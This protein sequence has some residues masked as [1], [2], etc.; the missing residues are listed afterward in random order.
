MPLESSMMGSIITRFDLCSTYQSIF[1][2]IPSFFSPLGLPDRAR[3]NR[4]AN[5]HR[6]SA[7]R[8]EVVGLPHISRNNFAMIRQNRE[9]TGA[10]KTGKGRINN[11]S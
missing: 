9:K 2:Y 6:R 3:R 5:I 1:F 10:G 8:R 7:R 11:E 4:A